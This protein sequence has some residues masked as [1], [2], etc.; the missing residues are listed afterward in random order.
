MSTDGDLREEL[1]ALVHSSAR[2]L[3]D[4]DYQSF[5][6]LFE[7]TGSYRVEVKAPEL[8]NPMI[9][10]ELDRGELQARYESVDKHEWRL[11]EQTRLIAVDRIDLENGSARTSASVAIYHTDDDGRTTCYAVA[12]Y[13]DTWQQTREGWRIRERVVALRTRLLAI[14]SPLPL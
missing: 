14:P 5:V 8:P 13:N 7:D 3:D 12:R 2:Y 9:W 10:M 11:Y 1:R 4:R 6:A